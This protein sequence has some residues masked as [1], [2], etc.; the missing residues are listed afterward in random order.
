MK[1]AGLMSTASQRPLARSPLVL[2]PAPDAER[3]RT[4]AR[5]PRKTGW[6]CPGWSKSRSWPP[7]CSGVAG[8]AEISPQRPPGHRQRHAYRAE[9]RQGCL[10]S[11][12]TRTREGIGWCVGLWFRSGDLLGA[13]AGRGGSGE[14][15]DRRSARQRAASATLIVQ[16]CRQGAWEAE[17]HASAVMQAW[18]GLG[19]SGLGGERSG[20]S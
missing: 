5:E 20:G 16:G 14:P 19:G 13:P 17:G 2:T 4:C 3:T 6:R 18:H 8:R 10:W 7:S 1:I 11:R 12:G 15:K 9:V